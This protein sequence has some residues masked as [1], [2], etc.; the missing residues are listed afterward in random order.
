MPIVN[1]TGS[2]SDEDMYEQMAEITKLLNFL[3][4]GG[5]DSL[6]IKSL[7]A[8]K[9]TAGT[10]DAGKI[11]VRVD[12]NTGAY[13]EIGPTGMVIND[14]TTDVFK[15][16]TAGAVTM[17]KAIVQ[18]ASGYPKVIMNPSGNLLGVY[19]DANNYTRFVPNMAGTPGLEFYAGGLQK[20]EMA[21]DIGLDY[22]GFLSRVN[23]F[24]T[25]YGSIYLN[26]LSGVVLVDDFNKIG[27]GTTTSYTTLQADL[28]AL[29]AAIAAN[30]AAITAK[31]NLGASTGSAGSANGGIAPGT[32][33]MVSGGGTATWNGIPAHSHTQT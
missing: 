8:D 3:L 7:T 10:I 21:V 25:A 1:F 20:G 9:I 24:I 23:A 27:R 15:V 14:G 22:F 2:D 16:T 28:N 19:L 11:T 18:S 31:A 29:T 4:N 33:L 26:P 30:T 6:N 32:V 17:T 5:L 12:Y 13:I